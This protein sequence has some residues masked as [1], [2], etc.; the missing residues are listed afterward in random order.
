[1]SKEKNLKP[2][3]KGVSGNPGGRPHWKQV[4]ELMKTETNQE[5]LAVI[6][7]KVFDLAL[8]GNMRAI[9][10][11]AD[12]LEGK[13]AQRVEVSTKSDEPIRVFDFDN[14]YDVPDDEKADLIELSMKPSTR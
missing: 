10:F 12:R 1:M 2:F 4:T 5:K 13:V 3:E 11:I 7:D 9:E 8:E 6:V 14:P